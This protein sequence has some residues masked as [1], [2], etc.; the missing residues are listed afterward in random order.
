MQASGG[1]SFG[2]K[3]DRGVHSAMLVY[4]RKFTRD[5]VRANTISGRKKSENRA[6]CHCRFRLLRDSARV[7]RW[8]SSFGKPGALGD[9]FPASVRQLCTVAGAA[10]VLWIWCG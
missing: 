9:Q 10:V 4:T 3:V 2:A 7:W 5:Q 8:V 1:M 6:S